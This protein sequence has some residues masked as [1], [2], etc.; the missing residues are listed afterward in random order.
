MNIFVGNLSQ[1]VAEGDLK[2]MFNE[3]GEITS[4]RIITDRYTNRSKGFA[5]VDMPSN[6]EAQKAIDTLNDT[7]LKGKK[8]VVNKARPR[9]EKGPSKRFRR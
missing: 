8:I 6:E 2:G 7:E 1:E 3:I 5:F 9:T 4:I